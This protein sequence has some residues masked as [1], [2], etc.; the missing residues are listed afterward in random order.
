MKYYRYVVEDIKTGERKQCVAKTKADLPKG[1][2][3][4]SCCG[5]YEKPDA[6]S[7]KEKHE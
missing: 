3:I 2:K 4:V 7:G 1:Y 6:E 5:F